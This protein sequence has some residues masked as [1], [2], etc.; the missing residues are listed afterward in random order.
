MLVFFYVKIKKSNVIGVDIM[1]GYAVKRKWI[2][3]IILAVAIITIAFVGYFGY[4]AYGFHQ[5]N[6][7]IYEPI[8]ETEMREEPVDTNIFEPVSVLMLGIDSRDGIDSGRSDTII[9]ATIDPE[10]KTTT[11][12]SIPRDSYVYIEGYGYDKINHA[13]AFGGA[14][15]AVQAI[16]Q[17]LD[18]PIDYYAAIDFNGFVS[19]VDVFGGVTV[20]NEFSFNY[21]GYSFAEGELH[22][23]GDEAL[24]YS[25]MRYDDPEGDAGRQMRQQQVIMSL[26]D[27]VGTIKSVG[28]ISKIFDVLGDRISSNLSSRTVWDMMWDYDSALDN[29]VN[30]QLKF[31]GFTGSDGVYYAGID[32]EVRVQVSNTLRASLGLVVRDRLYYIDQGYN[33][34]LENAVPNETTP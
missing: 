5:M 32:D 16:E 31:D 30:I 27:E 34:S 18:I 21:D 3:I 6:E 8:P 11:V 14:K 7:E 19:L 29:V 33:L 28:Q 24:A 10:D 17:L 23:N 1:T 9:V 22:L 15:L 12:L 26:L 4:L 2:L 25:R 20:D 13:Y